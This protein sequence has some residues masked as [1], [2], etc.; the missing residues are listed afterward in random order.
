MKFNKALHL[1]QS[2][3]KHQHSLDDEYVDSRPME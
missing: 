1:G 3:P 2:N